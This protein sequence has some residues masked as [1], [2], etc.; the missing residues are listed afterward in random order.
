MPSTSIDSSSDALLNTKQVAALLG[1]HPTTLRIARYRQNFTELPW[2][3]IGGA[4]R[5]RRED[6]DHFI[7]AN[8]KGDP[9]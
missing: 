4:V 9:R 8:R 7:H 3:K 6:V 2:V 5:Y 1:I